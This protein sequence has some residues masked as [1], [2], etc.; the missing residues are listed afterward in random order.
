MNTRFNLVLPSADFEDSEEIAEEVKNEV[1]R[2]EKVFSRFDSQ[3]EL[4]KF[5]KSR[6][7]DLSSVSGDLSKALKISAEY[8]ELTEGYFNPSYS[9]ETDLG[10]LG[11]GFALEEVKKILLDY[12]LSRAFI[13]FGESSI[14]A[15]GT[16]PHGDCWEIA[17]CNPFRENESLGS[18]KLL[19][20]SLSVSGFSFSK[21]AGCSY[22][23]VD[24]NTG[25]L[26]KNNM[27]VCVLSESCIES[28]VLSTAVYA[29][30]AEWLPE[31]RVFPSAET[32]VIELNG[33]GEII[34]KHYVE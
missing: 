25:R 9:S 15:L 14:Y 8:S 21:N 19:N 27:L 20:S 11:K 17:V 24:P 28:E 10:G 31:K 26:A 4:Y 13:S 29:S 33:N 30:S 1:L 5:N 2:L 16:H 6:E 7:K 12:S 34:R 23:L 32:A 3:A 18:F 22:H